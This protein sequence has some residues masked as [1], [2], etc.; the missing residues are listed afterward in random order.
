MPMAIDGRSALAA[1]DNG[2]MMLR[3]VG[4]GAAREWLDS[5]V[6]FLR[7][8]LMAPHTAAVAYL[9][10]RKDLMGRATTLT[11]WGGGGEQRE[12]LRLREPEWIVLHGWTGDGLSLLVTRWSGGRD[13]SG[14][15]PIRTLW[16]VPI[17]GGAPVSTGL[18]MEGLRDISLHPDGRQ[19]AFNARFKR[20]ESWVMENLIPNP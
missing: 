4:N 13:A 6:T 11:V 3:E 5:G 12:L 18:A 9:A 20:S 17:T 8:H 19:I 1:F 2:R 10:D 16:R 7:R 14:N 15:S